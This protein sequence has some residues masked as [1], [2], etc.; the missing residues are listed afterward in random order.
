MSHI[1]DRLIQLKNEVQ[2]TGNGAYFSKNNI[3]KIVE[4]LLADLEENEKENGWIPV[5][6]R[7]PEEHDSIFA[8]FKGTDNWKRGM[9]EKTSKYVIATVAF[10]DG[11]VLVEQAHTTDGIWRT[12]KKVLGGTVVAWMDYPEPYKED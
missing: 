9:F 5:S 1:K 11:T 7:L 3:S 4:L 8:K 2:N 12:D 10:D 6:Q